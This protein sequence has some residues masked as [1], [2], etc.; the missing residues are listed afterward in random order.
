[1]QSSTILKDKNKWFCLASGRV[2]PTT[3]T[4]NGRRFVW[5]IATLLLVEI[6][7]NN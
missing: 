2:K 4:K 7:H 5:V 1:M 6:R 3:L